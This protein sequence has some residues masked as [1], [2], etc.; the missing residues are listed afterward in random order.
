MD[1]VVVVFRIFRSLH[2]YPRGWKAPGRLQSWHSRVYSGSF[3]ATAGRSSCRVWHRDPVP[4][5]AWRRPSFPR[6]A[7]RA[8]ESGIHKD[9]RFGG[10]TPAALAR[11]GRPDPWPSWPGLGRTDL[12]WLRQGRLPV[13]T[14]L[15][16][17]PVDP[18]G[19]SR[20]PSREGQAHSCHRSLWLFP[21]TG[22]PFRSRP[23]WPGGEPHGAASGSHGDRG[24]R[25]TGRW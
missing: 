8:L 15:P 7:V 11:L 18:D 22:L 4:S 1:S 10:R 3:R 9:D 13:G 20:I 17:A 21:L 16:R 23:A 12:R 25:L 19:V 24:S 6:R 14:T 5:P 2:G